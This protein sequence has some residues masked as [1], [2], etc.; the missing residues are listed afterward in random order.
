M[1]VPP[2]ARRQAHRD[3]TRRVVLDAAYALFE[4][5]GYERTTM[6]AVAGRAGV[7]LGTIFVHFA[8]KEALLAAAFEADLG[9]EIEEAFATLPARGIRAQLLHLA[10]R[11][12]AFYA[13]R[14]RLA[15]ELVRHGLFV[16]GEERTRL[17][18]QVQ[19]F[20]AEV[21]R[22][23]QAAAVAGEV[24]AEVAAFDAA[25]GFWADYFT[26]LV[27]GLREDQVSTR[28][29]LRTLE[30]LLELRFAG[31]APRGGRTSRR[32]P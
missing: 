29:Q 20:L 32:W 4:E 10:R 25:L 21:A 17:G 28:R 23:F 6:R 1:A 12:Y 16:E 26:V 7:A 19:A 27:G 18:A 13:R 2:G 9:R 8:D 3:S 15:R 5:T 14:P 24:R 11:L 31:L 22:L 30:T